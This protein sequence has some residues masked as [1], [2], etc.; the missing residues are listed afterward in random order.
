MKEYIFL[1]LKTD[2]TKTVAQKTQY[3]SQGR[4]TTEKTSAVLICIAKYLRLQNKRKTRQ[5]QRSVCRSKTAKS[6]STNCGGHVFQVFFCYFMAS[7]TYILDS[8]RWALPLNP[9]SSLFRPPC[10][11]E[12]T[13]SSLQGL[14]L[15]VLMRKHA[16]SGRWWK[17]PSSA[18]WCNQLKAH[19][20]KAGPC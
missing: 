17:H 15:L 14:A 13:L 18:Q 1:L 6:L 5:Q 3:W 8:S 9:F 19:R 12:T 20:K 16:N 4:A 11:L 10:P 7:H 2:C